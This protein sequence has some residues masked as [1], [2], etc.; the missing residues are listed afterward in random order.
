MVSSTIPPDAPRNQMLLR[1]YFRVTFEQELNAVFDPQC[2]IA[3]E[4]GQKRPNFGGDFLCEHLA[5]G[6]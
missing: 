1:R 6:L 4:N 2:Y 5:E 3:S